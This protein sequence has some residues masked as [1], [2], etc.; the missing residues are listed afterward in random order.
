M[1][2]SRY[3]ISGSRLVFRFSHDF[4]SCASIFRVGTIVLVLG[5]LLQKFALV[6]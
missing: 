5:P 4:H 2:F 3:L 6:E 1:V